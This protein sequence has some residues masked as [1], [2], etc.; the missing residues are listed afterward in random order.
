MPDVSHLLDKDSLPEFIAQRPNLDANRQRI[1]GGDD[2]AVTRTGDEYIVS[3]LGDMTQFSSKPQEQIE[4]DDP[5]ENLFFRVSYSDGVATIKPGSLSH[6]AWSDG[7]WIP[8]ETP[9]AESSLPVEIPCYIYAVVPLEL[10]SNT[11]DTDDGSV[12]F[13]TLSESV[14]IEGNPYTIDVAMTTDYKRVDVSAIIISQ[15]DDEGIFVAKEAVDSGSDG[16]FHARIAYINDSGVVEQNHV[17][18]LPVPQAFSAR[19]NSITV[20]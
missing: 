11:T 13:N 3:S 14:T 2:V 5:T 16:N 8:E 17:G 20:T 4:P 6:M 19:P 1:Y 15:I 18:V 7:F 9:T 12:P 10:T